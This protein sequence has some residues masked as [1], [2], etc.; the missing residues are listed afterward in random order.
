MS[1]IVHILGLWE[2]KKRKSMTSHPVTFHIS[3]L[4]SKCYSKYTIVVSSPLKA[5]H[6]PYECICTCS[7]CLYQMS[8]SL[9][10][11]YSLRTHFY[12]LSTYKI[13]WYW[14]QSQLQTIQIF[15]VDEPYV[16]MSIFWS[17]HSLLAQLRSGVLPHI[18]ETSRYFN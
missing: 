2:R 12:S 18:I 16:Q 4:S 15:R 7:S 13:G 9:R 11:L 14:T 17:L 8:L 1:L 3:S 10:H 5:S 6:N